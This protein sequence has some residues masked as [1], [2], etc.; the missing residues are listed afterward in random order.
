MRVGGELGH[1]RR[2]QSSCLGQTTL[3]DGS[4]V[5]ER[6]QEARELLTELPIVLRH[7]DFQQ[8]DGV[9]EAAQINRV[10]L[11]TFDS[12]GCSGLLTLQAV[13]RPSLTR[14]LCSIGSRLCSTKRYEAAVFK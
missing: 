2:R 4:G 13:H 1:I 5:V 14:L 8:P 11:R 7:C 6:V 10:S 9:L 3:Q 12:V